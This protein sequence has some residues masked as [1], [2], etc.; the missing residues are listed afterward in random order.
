MAKIGGTVSS[1]FI[2]LEVDHFANL[3]LWLLKKVK[4]RTEESRYSNTDGKTK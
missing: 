3:P 1:N 2:E 4:G